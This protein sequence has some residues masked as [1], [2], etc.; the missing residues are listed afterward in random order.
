MF[1]RFSY[2]TEAIFRS[3]M[4][5]YFSSISFYFLYP[6][7]MYLT[8]GKLV[9]IIPTYLPG[10]NEN[11]TGGF[12]TLSCYH[13]ILL[14][15]SFIGISCSDLLFTMLIANTPI[16][17]NLIEM[18]VKELN[19]CLEEKL[20]DSMIKFKLRNILLMHREMTELS[21]S[22]SRCQVKH[23]SNGFESFT[24]FNRFIA[25]MD[26]SFFKICFAQITGA[27]IASCIAIFVI[28]IVSVSPNHTQF[29]CQANYTQ[30]RLVI[31]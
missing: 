24:H 2:Y 21:L 27:A 28:I 20:G 30:I 25:T 19:V 31:K 18:E 11:T 15:L 17:A 13:T 16:M 1:E 22:W 7:Y 26:R 5:L 8:E 3:G 6:I 10:I 4:A 23:R 9:A 29:R 12:I 14:V